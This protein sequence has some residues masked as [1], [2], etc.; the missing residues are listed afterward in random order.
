[1][2]RHYLAK[3]FFDL[4]Q[5]IYR[6]MPEAAIGVDIMAGF[7]GEDQRAHENTFSL[8]RDLPVSYLHVFPFSPRKGT[9]A[10]ELPGHVPSKVI[11]DRAREIMELGRKKREV[12]Y[13]SCVGD[14]FAVLTEGWHSEEEKMIEGFSDNY[15]KV[16]FPSSHL[17]KNRIVQM[18][19]EKIEKGFLIGMPKICQGSNPEG[20]PD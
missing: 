9:V 19:I 8:I 1:M 3:Q 15:L 12:F 17:L 18:K 2:N 6:V 10:A 11:K 5:R 4:I 7:P 20:H 16:I 13:K 14:E